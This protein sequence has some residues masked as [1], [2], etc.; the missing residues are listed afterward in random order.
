MTAHFL[1]DESEVLVATAMRNSKSRGDRAYGLGFPI[2]LSVVEV[3]VVLGVSTRTV[4]RMLQAGELVVYRIRRQV[5]VDAESV[6]RLLEISRIGARIGLR[7]LQA[8]VHRR[9]AAPPAP[10]RQDEA[11][12]GLVQRPRNLSRHRRPH[13]SAAEARPTPPPAPSRR[14]GTR[15]N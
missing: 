15:R 3:A 4:P 7:H 13:R 2:L 1:M 6:T 11:H 9:P 12:D 14:C 10:S 8:P 5:R